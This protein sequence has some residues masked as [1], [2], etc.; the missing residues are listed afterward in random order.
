MGGR[1]SARRAHRVPGQRGVNK[2]SESMA[3]T[4]V[5]RREWREAG[6]EVLVEV[7]L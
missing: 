6:L 1:H 2:R 5:G 4:G 3:G 7:M